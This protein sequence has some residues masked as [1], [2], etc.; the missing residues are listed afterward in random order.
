MKK[1]IDLQTE[2]EAFR[3]A[4]EME[5]LLKV[6]T[7]RPN[8]TAFY[9]DRLDD[10]D[11]LETWQKEEL[12]E[13]Y[14][15]SLSRLAADSVAYCDFSV[16]PAELKNLSDEALQDFEFFVRTHVPSDVVHKR[17]EDMGIDGKKLGGIAQQ[18]CKDAVEQHE[19]LKRIE[20]LGE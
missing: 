14:E 1:Y 11:C 19:T 2:E 10:W 4:A 15:E 9:R 16:T 13:S 20:K 12:S 3:W 17:C 7:K 6:P 5:V 8:V 18:M